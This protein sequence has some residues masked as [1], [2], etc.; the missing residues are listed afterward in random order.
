MKFDP[1]ENYFVEGWQLT[2]LADIM[3][4]L[5][6]DSDALKLGERRDLANKMNAILYDVEKNI[7]DK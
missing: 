5:Y 2:A 1:H 3:T 7:L 4:R 6:N